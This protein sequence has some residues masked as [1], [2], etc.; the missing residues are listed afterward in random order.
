MLFGLIRACLKHSKPLAVDI[1]LCIVK[2]QINLDCGYLWTMPLPNGA[3]TYTFPAEKL[4]KLTCST[5]Y[6][7]KLSSTV[8][9][10]HHVGRAQAFSQD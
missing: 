9:L 7:S 8:L 10:V 3:Y 5:V 6:S 2:R 4:A 1:G